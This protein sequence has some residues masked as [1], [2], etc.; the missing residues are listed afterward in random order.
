MPSENLGR[1]EKYRSVIVMYFDIVI[2]NI[3]AFVCIGVIF[4]LFFGFYLHMKSIWVFILAFL[5]SILV[6]PFLAKVRL[7]NFCLTK[8]E[9][10][11][12]KMLGKIK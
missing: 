9:N 2:R 10:F 3:I 1:Y 5:T 11:I 4:M 6:S 8:Y 12:M 7:G